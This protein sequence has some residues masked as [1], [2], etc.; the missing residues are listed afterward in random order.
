[1]SGATIAL[2]AEGLERELTTPSGRLI[3]FFRRAEGDFIVLGAGG[4]MGPSLSLMLRRAIDIARVE[5]KLIAVSK[6]SSKG[7][8]ERLQSV[9]IETIVAD[10]L[11]Q[12]S[13]IALPNVE[14]VIDMV[15]QK[16]GTTGGEHNSWALN[17]FLPGRIAEKFRDSRIVHFSTG[18][19]YPFVSAKSRGSKESDAPGPVGEYAQS[20]LGGERLLEY[21]SRKY[22][23]QV[24]TLRLNYAV[25]LRYGV[26]HDIAKSVMERRPIDLRMGYANVIWQGDA[27]DIAIRS[28]SAASSPPRVLNVTGPEKIPVRWLA[29]EFGRLLGVR[30]V[31]KNSEE[32]TALLNNAGSTLKTFGRPRVSLKQMISWVADWL[33]V[34][35]KSLDKPT[36]FQERTGRF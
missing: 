34:G 18:N 7:I 13:L 36:H 10:L 22:G 35:G 28:L 33:T 29:K 15:A 2:S 12:D 14:N 11:D 8:K 25:E 30:P 26:L 32:H 23:T 1:M 4:K 24:T 9:G 3:E 21:F 17:T 16:F 19:V 31:F 6:F 27:N 5:K 20:R